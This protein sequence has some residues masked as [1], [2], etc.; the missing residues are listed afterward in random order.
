[1]VND[2]IIR[3]TSLGCTYR[4][5]TK[6]AM[7]MKDYDFSKFLETLVN[8]ETPDMVLNTIE[9]MSTDIMSYYNDHL[10]RRQID[11]E[12]VRF[13][14]HILYLRYLRHFIEEEKPEYFIR[15][16][17]ITSRCMSF[18]KYTLLKAEESLLNEYG[19]VFV[20]YVN[21]T[22]FKGTATTLLMML[23]LGIITK[24]GLNGLVETERKYCH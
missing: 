21:K 22:G 20:P 12:L 8:Q 5:K 24:E 13:E 7:L 10:Y 6:E 1:M 9:L 18:Y 3:Y 23:D 19:I 15:R 11:A 14:K 17:F 2:G 16:Q 4:I